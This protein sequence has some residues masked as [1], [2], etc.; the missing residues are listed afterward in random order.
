LEPWAPCRETVA[1]W[2]QSNPTFFIQY[3]RARDQGYDVLGELALDEA[4]GAAADKDQVQK[5]RLAWDARRWHLS[6]MLPKKYGDKLETKSEITGP[7]G[8]PLQMQMVLDVLLSP[9][10]LERLDAAEIESIRSAALKLAGPD[11]VVDADYE[12]VRASSEGAG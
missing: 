6:K 2:A 7:G 9:A 5:A 1:N 12:E 4:V 3:A 11:N 8:G 10:S